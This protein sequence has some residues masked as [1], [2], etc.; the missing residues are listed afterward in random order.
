MSANRGR[1]RIAVLVPGVGEGDVATPVIDTFVNSLVGQVDLELFAMRYPA[2]RA[3]YQRDGVRVHPLGG[4]GV[5]YRHLVRGAL[6]ALRAEHHRKPFD[7]LHGLWLHE[8]ATTAIMAGALLRRPVLASIG[9]AEVVSLPDIHYGGML[10]R[11]GRLVNRAALA[12]A[13]LVTGGSRYI[14]NLARRVVPRRDPSR[15]R[16]APL[17]VDVERFVPGD[18]HAYDPAAPRLLHAASL[19]PVKDQ[20]TLLRAFQQVAQVLP[21]AHLDIAG[22]DPFGHRSGLE[23]LAEDL[24]ITRQVSFLGAVPHAE[25]Q[26]HYS[27]ADLFVLSSRHENHAMV[28]VESAACGLPTVGTAVGALPELAP[29]A[30]LTVPTADPAALARGILTLLRDP[31]RL[32]ATGA[33]ARARVLRDYAAA[34]AAARWLALYEELAAGR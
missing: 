2:R 6:A 12:R 4:P 33:A 23:R 29:D 5:E 21:G 10:Q 31:D 1:L 8:P 25:L 32:A 3:P 20:T 27:T 28:V 11:S 34:P 22:E 26:M 7:V 9:G 13:T 16:L 18:S 17:G 14:L 19:I 15:F 30:A 24:G